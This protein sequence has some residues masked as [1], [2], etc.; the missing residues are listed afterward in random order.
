MQKLPAPDVKIQP[1]LTEG[2]CRQHVWPE[3]R[4][5]G[6][7][8]VISPQAVFAAGG[9]LNLCIGKGHRRMAAKLETIII[10]PWFVNTMPSLMQ[11]QRLHQFARET[12]NGIGVEPAHN[13]KMLIKNGF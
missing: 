1:F 5:K 3:G 12:G 11:P 6:P 7:A 4:I 2:S 8:H 13:P 9:V 10:D